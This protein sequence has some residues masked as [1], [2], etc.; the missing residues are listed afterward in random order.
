MT[1]TRASPVMRETAVP[2]ATVTFDRSRL[3]T[4][5]RMPDQCFPDE[6]C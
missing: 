5:M 4:G 3:L 1:A 2:A 6:G